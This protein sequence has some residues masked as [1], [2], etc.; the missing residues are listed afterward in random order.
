MILVNHHEN[1]TKIARSRMK[2][3][4]KWLG[5]GFSNQ[6]CFTARLFWPKKSPRKKKPTAATLT[7][8]AEAFAESGHCILDRR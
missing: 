6:K 2:S 5:I 3:C 8:E 7:T 4:Q 1:L